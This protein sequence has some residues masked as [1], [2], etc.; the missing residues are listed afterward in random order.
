MRANFIEYATK[1]NVFNFISLKIFFLYTEGLQRIYDFNFNL[2]SPRDLDKKGLHR[3]TDIKID[4]L[5]KKSLVLFSFEIR[6]P[7]NHECSDKQKLTLKTHQ[8]TNQ[9]ASRCIPHTA[10]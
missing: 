2:I 6:N 8:S 9:S 4:K 7:K 10:G 1:T 3:R 5:I